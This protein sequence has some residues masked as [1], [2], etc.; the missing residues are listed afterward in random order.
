MDK[1]LGH[2]AAELDLLLQYP[3]AIK[4]QVEEYLDVYRREGGEYLAGYQTPQ[5]SWEEVKALKAQGRAPVLRG[6]PEE[7]ETGEG[8]SSKDVD[9]VSLRAVDDRSLRD[10]KDLSLQET[11][12]QSTN[13]ALVGGGGAGGLTEEERAGVPVAPE[14][15]PDQQRDLVAQAELRADVVAHCHERSRDSPRSS[16]TPLEDRKSPCSSFGEMEANL[17]EVKSD[18]PDMVMHGFA[19]D[20]DLNALD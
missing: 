3:K 8:Q 20:G 14:L 13:R 10:M 16:L 5:L 18:E 11:V 1:M 4:S 7:E 17:S 9:T 6:V 2:E 19:L 12:D 15:P